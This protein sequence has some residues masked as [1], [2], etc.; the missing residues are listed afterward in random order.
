MILTWIVFL[1]TIP[2]PYNLY[3]K[4]AYVGIYGV[5]SDLDIALISRY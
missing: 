5:S 3:E 2:I 4:Y 1:A